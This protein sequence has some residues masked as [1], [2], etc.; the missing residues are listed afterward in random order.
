MLG[1]NGWYDRMISMLW[2]IFGILFCM[3]SDEFSCVFYGGDCRVVAAATLGTA[4]CSY[5]ATLKYLTGIYFHDFSLK[6]CNFFLMLNFP[7]LHNILK[8]L[9]LNSILSLL[10]RSIRTQQFLILI[11]QYLQTSLQ[12]KYLL[13]LHIQYLMDITIF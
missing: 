6:C 2:I 7:T 3:G 8:F 11:L 12:L 5:S 4:L 10:P 9:T 1:V 13:M